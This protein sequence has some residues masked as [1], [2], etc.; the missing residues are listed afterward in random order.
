M[1]CMSRNRMSGWGL[2]WNQTQ[3]S[4]M[5]PGKS[6]TSQLGR[7][8]WIIFLSKRAAGNSSSIIAAVIFVVM[9]IEIRELEVL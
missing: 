9:M 3:D 1:S 2:F 5:V 6:S 8:S 4:S 7:N